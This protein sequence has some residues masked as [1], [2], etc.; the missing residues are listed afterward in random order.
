M[1]KR[2]VSTAPVIRRFQCPVCGGDHPRADHR[3][4]SRCHGPLDDVRYATC[5]ACRQHVAERKARKDAERHLAIAAADTNRWPFILYRIELA[6]HRRAGRPFEEA[7]PLALAVVLQDPRIQRNHH[8]R[9]GVSAA[10][11]ATLDAWGAAYHR[12]SLPSQI[13]ALSLLADMA[14]S[15]GPTRAVS[16]L[17]A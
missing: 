7:Q 17:V 13:T 11:A 6:K 3:E 12:R 5:G 16:E 4:C 15:P 9:A 14:E 10:I 1:A 8:L 2:K